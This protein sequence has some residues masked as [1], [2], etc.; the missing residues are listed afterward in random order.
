MRLLLTISILL[1][2]DWYAFQAVRTL[3]QTWPA[4]VRAMAYTFHWL[5]P[6]ALAI[7]MIAS[8]N[9]AADG[10]DKNTLTVVRTLFFIIY[11]SKIL[12]VSILFIDDLRRVAMVAYNHFV[13]SGNYDEGRSRFVAQMSL[14]MGGI[15]FVSLIYGMIRNPYRYTIFKETVRLK[16]LP[17]ALDGLR[18]VQISDIHSGSFLFKEPVENAIRIINEQKADLAF[19]T[20]DLVNSMA[21]EVEPFIDIFSG[22]RAKYGVFSV[23]GNHDYGD[24]HRWDTPEDKEQNMENLKDAHRQMGWDLLLNENRMVEINGE[25][26]AVLGV[27]NYSSHPRFP[28]YGD[29]KKAY[30]GA[31]QAPLKLLL[32]HDPSHWLDQ[33]TSD[34][35]DIDLTFSG[36]THGMQFGVEIP[37][38]IKWSPIK[39]VYKQWAG[40][41]QEGQ[42]YLYVNRGLGY[43]GYPGRVGILPEV[44]VIDLKRG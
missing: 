2:L 32:S 3:A 18:I 6:I 17:K 9:S 8:A 21:K 13:G 27:E 12:V 29:L 20:G 36:H 16:N 25:Q 28:K 30:N 22:I 5:V 35:T 37:G 26:V 23:L 43:L 31:G 24:Y 34:Y 10:I 19:F 38:W 42:Q 39:Y 14:F 7:W 41:Y 33:V 11:I 4:A 40:L 44:T 15:P 1:L